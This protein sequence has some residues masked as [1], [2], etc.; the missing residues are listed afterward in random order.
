MRTLLSSSIPNGSVVGVIG[1]AVGFIYTVY[2]H[3][4]FRSFVVLFIF[5]FVLKIF[6]ISPSWAL[7]LPPTGFSVVGFAVIVDGTFTRL[8]ER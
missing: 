5:N 2:C 1:G 4:P 7:R 8:N 3:P 6:F